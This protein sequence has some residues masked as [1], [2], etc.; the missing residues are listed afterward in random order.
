[1]ATRLE[2]LPLVA[3]AFRRGEISWSKARLIC[4]V[5]DVGSE[6]AWLERTRGRTVRELVLEIRRSRACVVP[7]A[8]DVLDDESD[9]TD[10]EARARASR[11]SVRRA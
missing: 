8:G 1:V 6:A 10:G 4:S 9:A 3:A 7:E 5:A 11:S 2:A